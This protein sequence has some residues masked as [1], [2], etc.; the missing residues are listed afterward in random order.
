MYIYIY[1]HTVIHT[2]IHIYIYT[3]IGLA[4]GAGF[5]SKSKT[6]ITCKKLPVVSILTSL[7]ELP[8]SK[9][10]LSLA[11]IWVSVVEWQRRLKGSCYG[12]PRPSLS[13][14]CH[15]R[16]TVPYG[17]KARSLPPFLRG[18]LSLSLSVSGLTLLCAH[19]DRWNPLWWTC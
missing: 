10:L 11:D 8:T 9:L 1:I 14:P 18:S 6:D 17:C 4:I 7:S 13:G 2:Y 19:V 12:R 15:T 5:H 3:A 16:N